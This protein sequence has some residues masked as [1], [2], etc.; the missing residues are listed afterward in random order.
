MPSRTPQD[1]T[2]TWFNPDILLVPALRGPFATSTGN[3]QDSGAPTLGE[4]PEY[5]QARDEFYNSV[6]NFYSDM[7]QTAND[8]EQALRKD[9]YDRRLELSQND[10]I[11]I[12]RE[13]DLLGQLRGELSVQI[14]FLNKETLGEDI[15]RLLDEGTLRESMQISTILLQRICK[16]YDDFGTTSRMTFGQNT[17]DRINEMMTDLLRQRQHVEDLSSTNNADRGIQTS[18]LPAAVG[19]YSQ[20]TEWHLN[21]FREFGENLFEYTS[22][23]TQNAAELF[24][25]IKQK[26][27]TLAPDMQETMELDR[28][29]ESLD[30]TISQYKDMA[31]LVNEALETGDL[32]I[33]P[34]PENFFSYY[35]Q[36]KLAYEEV[37]VEMQAAF[38]RIG[39]KIEDFPDLQQ[40]FVDMERDLSNIDIL[41]G[42]YQELYRDIIGGTP[43]P[44]LDM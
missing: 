40:I 1:R 44:S 15:S 13:I 9:L 16:E 38:E 2:R 14:E 31:R 30:N 19:A 21:R 33:L 43:A 39:I 28:V 37:Y 8:I 26:L 41:R 42:R 25:E 32:S 22:Q 27:Q 10:I 20:V 3:F 23:F 17:I 35:E 24:G 29:F 7:M 5:I 34:N 12:Q 36:I 6:G 18:A 4:S 11:R